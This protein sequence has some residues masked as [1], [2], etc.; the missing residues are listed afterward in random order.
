MIK[1]IAL[2]KRKQGI[3]LEEF[4]RR[5]EEVHAPMA[6][7]LFPTMTKYVRN[8]VISAPF[9][10]GAGEPEFDCITEECFDNQEDFQAWRD[11]AFGEA[12][13]AIRDDER[14]FLHRKRT[15]YLLVDAVR[16]K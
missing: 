10:P 11:I 15:V 14:N 7:R 1:A 5:Y 16:S 8:Y 13:R 4:R 6:V 12:G 3:T 9:A 2:L